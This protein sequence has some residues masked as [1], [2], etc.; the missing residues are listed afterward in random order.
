M[1]TD[2][3]LNSGQVLRGEKSIFCD[4]RSLV[5]EILSDNLRLQ[6]SQVSGYSDGALGYCQSVRTDEGEHWPTMVADFD[7]V[8]HRI[9]F[10]N[11]QHAA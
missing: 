5:F 9:T 11:Q 4:P 10:S 6:G 2:V 7:P 1:P 8:K 3:Q